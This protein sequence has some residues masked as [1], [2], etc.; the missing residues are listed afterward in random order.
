MRKGVSE[1]A[2]MTGEH[3]HPQKT[4]L[5]LFPYTNRDKYNTKTGKA[6][7]IWGKGSEPVYTA[8]EAFD[9][10]CSVTFD[11]IRHVNHVM[12]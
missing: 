3:Y 7:S 6:S 4:R 8:M 11:I 12:E 1:I 9:M 10:Q 5:P 2:C